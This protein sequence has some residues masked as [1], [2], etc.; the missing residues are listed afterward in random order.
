MVVTQLLP[1]RVA[2][3]SN[4]STIIFILNIYLLTKIKKKRTRMD[5]FKEVEDGPEEGVH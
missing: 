4:R 1:I 3:G 2:L 5:H